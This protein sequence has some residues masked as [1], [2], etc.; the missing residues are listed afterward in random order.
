[1][2]IQDRII[3][4]TWEEQKI[5]LLKN[6]TFYEYIYKLM[7]EHLKIYHLVIII[8][9]LL[10]SSSL[11]YMLYLYLHYNISFSSHSSPSHFISHSTS[12]HVISSHCSLTHIL[13]LVYRS[14]EM[15]LIQD[16]TRRYQNNSALFTNIYIDA[17]SP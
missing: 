7:R 4:D 11:P 2:Y 16:D 12:Y 9:L 17:F 13:L 5:L 8:I 14:P 1:M 15:A 6:Y 10:F 3:H